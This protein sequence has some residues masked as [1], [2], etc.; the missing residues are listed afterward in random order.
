M[1]NPA[2][3]HWHIFFPRFK[4]PKSPHSVETC[5]YAA[6]QLGLKLG[7]RDRPFS[8][9]YS[10]KGCHAFESGD[11]KDMIFYGTDGSIEEMTEPLMSPLY[12]P[13]ALDSTAKGYWVC[14]LWNISNILFD[15][16]KPFDNCYFNPFIF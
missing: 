5:E 2:K 11:F 15:R 4:E 3:H 8:G 14:Y 12:R 7:G 10:T 1:P 16:I 13:I 6:N 9:K